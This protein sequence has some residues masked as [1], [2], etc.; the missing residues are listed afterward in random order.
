MSGGP[1]DCPPTNTIAAKNHPLPYGIRI[2]DLKGLAWS[3]P[4]TMATPIYHASFSENR[5]FSKNY[6]S[7]RFLRQKSTAKKR[8]NFELT[9]TIANISVEATLTFIENGSALFLKF[10][11]IQLEEFYR[12]EFI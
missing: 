7:M 6:S 1:K 4:R 10:S 2:Q 12:A 5:S 11:E 9:L 3:G 8:Q